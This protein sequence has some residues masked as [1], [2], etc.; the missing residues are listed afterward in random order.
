M[1]MQS[2]L[3]KTAV[4]ATAACSLSIAN[5]QTLVNAGAE[6]I[7][8]KNPG[9]EITR[10]ALELNDMISVRPVDRDFINTALVLTDRGGRPSV[11][12]CVAYNANGNA[13]GRGFT[14]TAGNGV[15]I[16]LASDL[17]NGRDF[18]GKI[19]CKSRDHVSGTAFIIGPDFTDTRVHNAHDR[20]GSLISVPVAVSR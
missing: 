13:I 17:T 18:L 5:A 16:V 12:Y 8:E 4:A 10:N 9:V 3:Q 14:K 6:T 15:S 2:L 19:R 11:T 20:A 1:S 7:D